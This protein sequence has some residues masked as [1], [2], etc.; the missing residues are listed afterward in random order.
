VH[1]LGL[2]DARELSATLG[3]AQYEVPE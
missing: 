2:S 1:D 3:K